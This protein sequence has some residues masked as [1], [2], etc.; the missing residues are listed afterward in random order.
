[1]LA[2]KS[3]K[4]KLVLLV[5]WLMVQL[6]GRQDKMKEQD[7]MRWVVCSRGDRI[8]EVRTRARK[9]EGELGTICSVVWHTS[10]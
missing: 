4:S 10:F 9:S 7:E 3:V 5:G 8:G 6:K 2:Q 1:M